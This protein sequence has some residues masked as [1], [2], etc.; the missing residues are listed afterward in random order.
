MQQYKVVAEGWTVMV[1][2]EGKT[3]LEGMAAHE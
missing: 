3:L 2:L 1:S